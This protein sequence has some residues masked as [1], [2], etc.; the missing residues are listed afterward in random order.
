MFFNLIKE[1]SSYCL[2]FLAQ[3]VFP[4]DY[5]YLGMKIW[6]LIRV[7]I[8]VWIVSACFWYYVELNRRDIMVDT[9]YFTFE[10]SMGYEVVHLSKT[11]PMYSSDEAGDGPELPQQ[12]TVHDNI[13]GRPL[14]LSALTPV[15]PL[16]NN[17]T[18]L[19]ILTEM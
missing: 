15:T 17:V 11:G 6:R 3:I 9:E 7:Y 8:H 16:L 10:T 5:Q 12:S 2:G 18:V 4:W 14:T 13:N 1:N 19:I